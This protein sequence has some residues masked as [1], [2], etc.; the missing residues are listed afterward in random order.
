MRKLVIAWL[1]V[2]V[3]ASLVILTSCSPERR[4]QHH[5]KRAIALNPKILQSS[6]HD[7]LRIKDSVRITEKVN[8]TQKTVVITKDS[9]VITPATNIGGSV[10]SPCDS[11]GKLGIFDYTFGA[12]ANKLRIWSDGTQLRFNSSVDSLVST[13]HRYEALLSSTRD[14]LRSYQEKKDSAAVTNTNSVI[15]RTVPTRGF[16]W[17]SGLSLWVL[18]LAYAVYRVIKS[19]LVSRLRL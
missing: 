13:N 9:T 5:L 1:L 4:A 6:T 10:P 17:W 11:F 12:G 7:S 16:F 15:T 3:T 19:R 18:A 8:V 2:L 14:S